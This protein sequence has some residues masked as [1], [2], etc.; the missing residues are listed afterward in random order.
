MPDAG[1]ETRSLFWTACVVVASVLGSEE[2]AVHLHLGG[3][4]T[5]PVR[6]NSSPSINFLLQ[7]STAAQS[8]QIKQQHLFQLPR[9]RRQ[10]RK[11][12]LGAERGILPSVS[13]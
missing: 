5:E 6:S 4:W 2:K 10:Q 9:P 7:A 13:Q 1:T 3:A 8:V 11:D 12:R